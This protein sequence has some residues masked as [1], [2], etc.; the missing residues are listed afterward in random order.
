MLQAQS[1]YRKATN[2]ASHLWIPI[3]LRIHI[4]ESRE[5]RSITRYADVLHSLTVIPYTASLPLSDGDNGGRRSQARTVITYCTII[6][7][8]IW[9]KNRIHL[10]ITVIPNRTTSKPKPSVNP[11][12]PQSRSVSAERSGSISDGWPTSAA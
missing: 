1:F 6:I 5:W 8:L 12:V 2:S 4:R 10:R 7:S 9:I 11:D 3:R